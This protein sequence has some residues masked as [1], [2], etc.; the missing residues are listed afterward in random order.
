MIGLSLISSVGLP[1]PTG[2]IRRSSGIFRIELAK[3][4]GSGERPVA[5]RSP[6]GD[7]QRL[8]GL[9]EREAGEEAELDQL[10]PSGVDLRES[11]QGLVEVDQVV[12][13]GVIG[14]ESFEVEG[15]SAAGA[16]SLEPLP[17]SGSVEDD[18][19]HGLGGRGVEV[20]STVPV[21][22]GVRTDE[23]E[24]SLVDQGRGLERL[25]GVFEGQPTRGQASKLVVDQRQEI[26]GGLPIAQADGIEDSGHFSSVGVDGSGPSSDGMAIR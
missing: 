25:T 1:A 14:H 23:P 13:R 12:G 7:S 3:E 11:S 5:F 26:A 15:L 22:A 18:S 6:S 24:I 20:A 19:P 4:P 9:V 21:A 8:G 16:S 2:K 17:V 10:G